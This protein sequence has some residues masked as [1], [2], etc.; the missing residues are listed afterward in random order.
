VLEVL[1]GAA[2]L[3]L[4]VLLPVLEVVSGELER[5]G[6]GHEDTE[7]EGTGDGGR[8]QA[9]ARGAGQERAGEGAHLG[10]L[11]TSGK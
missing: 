11:S 3:L 1:G 2:D 6:G 7:C 10:L 9:P 8:C 5:G 4:D